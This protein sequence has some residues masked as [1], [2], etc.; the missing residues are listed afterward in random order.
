M[1]E[2]ETK[3]IL[4]LPIE[5]RELEGMALALEHCERDLRHS[6]KSAGKRKGNSS[7]H[8]HFKIGTK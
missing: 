2:E 6:G 5:V 1:K 7:M 8:C 4:L 3:S